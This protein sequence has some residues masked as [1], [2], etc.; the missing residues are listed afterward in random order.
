MKKLT[1]IA[2]L[3]SVGAMSACSPVHVVDTDNPDEVADMEHV[4]VLEYRDWEKAATKATD[5]LL[6]SN[7]LN[8]PNGGKYAIVIGRITNDTMQRIDTD[9]LIKKI[10]SQLTASGKV[11]IQTAITG[12]D[13]MTNTVRDQRANDEYKQDTIAGKGTLVAPELSLTGKMIQRN[14]KL[15]RRERVEYYFQLTLTEVKTGLSVW[16]HEQ[17]IIKEGSKAPTW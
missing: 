13:T 14:I 8:K 12:E 11:A 3:L 5:N 4:M 6:A 1:L 15:S 2:A 17:P 10:R 9:L 7:A 16:E